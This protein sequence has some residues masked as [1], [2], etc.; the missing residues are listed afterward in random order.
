MAVRVISLVGGTEACENLTQ[1]RVIGHASTDSL[2]KIQPFFRRRSCIMVEDIKMC[3]LPRKRI[4]LA[5]QLWYYETICDRVCH[6]LM[7]HLLLRIIF[8]KRLLFCVPVYCIWFIWQLFNNSLNPIVQV[9]VSTQ[10]FL[11][12][13][14]VAFLTNVH[15]VPIRRLSVYVWL[16]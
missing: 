9:L 11:L 3:S 5:C 10:T 4:G 13:V 6:R 8:A 7:L 15:F 12:L 2:V 1:N 14:L 16:I